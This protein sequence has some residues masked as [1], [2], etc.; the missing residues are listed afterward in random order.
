MPPDPPR[1]RGLT[2]PF[3]GTA[4]IYTIDNRLSNISDI[5]ALIAPEICFNIKVA[6]YGYRDNVSRFK[7]AMHCG[8]VGARATSSRC[9][10]CGR[11]HVIKVDCNPSSLSQFLS[12]TAEIGAF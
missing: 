11:S 7:S 2:V 5:S 12:R 3:A 8:I 1:K 6:C 9:G 10:Q 4:V